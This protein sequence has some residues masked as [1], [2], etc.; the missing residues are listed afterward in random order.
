MLLYSS[1]FIFWLIDLKTPYLQLADNNPVGCLKKGVNG[2]FGATANKY[3]QISVKEILMFGDVGYLIN[4]KII[5]VLFEV[6]NFIFMTR[7]TRKG[8]IGP[9]IVLIQK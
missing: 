4:L 3:S 9:L 8:L 7:G 1:G 5:F 6:C 2:R